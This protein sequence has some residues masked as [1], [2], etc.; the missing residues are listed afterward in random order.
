VKQASASFLKKGCPPG[1]QKTFAH[2]PHG[3]FAS[4]AQEQKFFGYFF[5]KSNFTALD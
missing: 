4:S 5:Q 3:G 2:W 1:E